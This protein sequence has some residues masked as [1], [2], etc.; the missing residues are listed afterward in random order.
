MKAKHL[1][2]QRLR[3]TP[4]ANCAANYRLKRFHWQLLALSTLSFSVSNENFG[5]TVSKTFF[6]LKNV[7]LNCKMSKIHV[8]HSLVVVDAEKNSTVWQRRE[9]NCKKSN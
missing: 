4:A 9:Q 6:F 5:F 1:P 3:N 7:F 2:C 8:N